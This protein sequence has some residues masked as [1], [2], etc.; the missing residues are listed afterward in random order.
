MGLSFLSSTWALG[1]LGIDLEAAHR[2]VHGRNAAVDPVG[3]FG[4]VG[5]LSSISEVEV[6]AGLGEF[7]DARNRGLQSVGRDVE[8]G[9]HFVKGLAG[10]EDARLR[11]DAHF[12]LMVFDRVR[13][14]F[15]RLVEERV[16]IFARLLENGLA[17]HVAAFE[18]FD[19][20]LPFLIDE[21]GAFKARVVDQFDRARNRVAHRIGLDL[22]HVDGG[23]AHFF[24]HEDAVALRAG[25]VRRLE[26]LAVEGIE[27]GAQRHVRAEAARRRPSR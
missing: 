21:D 17:H 14:V 4:E 2:V 7:V 8:G 24:G 11:E 1:C 13:A 10:L 9:R 27:L 15:H 25:Q 20:A 6:L 23:G 16:A 5:E 3:A 18:F 22:F 26:A 12:V 19:E